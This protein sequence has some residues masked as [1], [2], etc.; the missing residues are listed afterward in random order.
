MI[1]SHGEACAGR[2][3]AACGG[4]DHYPPGKQQRAGRKLHV[5]PEPVGS[6]KSHKRTHAP[7]GGSML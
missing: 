7:E 6:G 1:I 5:H 2:E 4:G 3:K